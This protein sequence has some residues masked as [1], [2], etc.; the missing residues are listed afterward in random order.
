MKEHRDTRGVV[1]T[2]ARPLEGGSQATKMW[3][4]G[5]GTPCEGG[6]GRTAVA[7]AGHTKCHECRDGPARRLTNGDMKDASGNGPERGVPHQP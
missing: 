5:G 6:G 3:A 1:A 4:Q 2:V 7:S